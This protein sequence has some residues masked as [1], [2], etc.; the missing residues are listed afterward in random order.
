MAGKL[1]PDPQGARIL[2]VDHDPA[3][4]ADVLQMMRAAGHDAREAPSG[5][6]AIAL[7][8]QLRPDL[9][10]LDSG[11]TGLDGAELC[12][13]LKDDPALEHAFV[14]HLV[15]RDRPVPAAVLEAG[16]DGFVARGLPHAELLARLE[17][18]LRVQRAERALRALQRRQTTRVQITHA[19]ATAR[20]LDEVAP[21]LLRALAVGTGWQLGELWTVPAG[22]ARLRRRAVWCEPGTGIEELVAASVALAL[23]PGEDPVGRAWATGQLGWIS[24]LAS[25]PDS[26][27]AD[28]LR[29]AG[30]RGAAVLPLLRGPGRDLVLVLMSHQAPPP[31]EDLVLMLGDVVEQLRGFLDRVEAEN[32]LRLQRNL[33]QAMIE[34][35][36][37]AVTLKDLD[38]HYLMLNGPAARI[39]GRAP[40]ELLGRRDVD[41]LPADFVV[42]LRAQEEEAV[43]NGV[44]S[45]AEFSFEV[46]EET[47]VYLSLK[48]VCR[49]GDGRILGTIGVTHDITEHRHAEERMR[50]AQRVEAL[51]RLAGGVAHDFNNLLTVITVNS[52]LALMGLEPDHPN[53]R[54]FVEIRDAA[55]RA[56]EL[57]RQLL[58]YGRRQHLN[59]RTLDLNR[60]LGDLQS[61]LRRLIPEN[62]VIGVHPGGALDP[63]TV[64]PTQIEQV[65]LNLAVNA[66]DAMPH[67]GHLTIETRN[68]VV[69]EGSHPHCP[70]MPPGRYVVLSV[71]DDGVGMDETTRG[72]IFEPFFTTK[73]MGHGTGLGLAMVYGTVKQ[74]GGW[75][76]VD[77]SEGVGTTFTILLPAASAPAEASRGPAMPGAVPHGDETLLLVED[78]A[79]VRDIS[80]RVL[81][82]CGYHVLVARDGAHAIETVR[83]HAGAIALMVSDVVMPRM[84][85][86]ELRERLLELRPDLRVLFVSGYADQAVLP[87]A[88]LEGGVPFLQKPFKPE[89]LARRVREALDARIEG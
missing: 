58:A 17:G 30:L 73:S 14:V 72:R 5:D 54:A 20:S 82:G 62:I 50:L 8:R 77:S 81:E 2:V 18:V 55:E 16:V 69:S 31:D 11:L 41:V 4:R 84:S 63:V 88:V 45:T 15:A 79:V 56:S 38:G 76:W 80:R 33:F 9:V 49:D 29:A 53:A 57:T 22:E 32:E 64:D 47:R 46:G 12:R 71:S 60:V 7:A 86:P 28:A 43:R 78:D 21:G 66:R 10:L 67:G 85:G 6:A 24:D 40:G 37:D 36:P 59:P 42:R 23:A 89:V 83:A 1:H 19:M 13:R 25:E 75:I 87:A 27:R 35:I 51:G 48:S 70:P 52:D 68:L 3:Q 44:S 34:S 61:L 65:V 39:L 26:R 74:S